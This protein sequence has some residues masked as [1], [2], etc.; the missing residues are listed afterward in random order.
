MTISVLDIFLSFFLKSRPGLRQL[1][2]DVANE[3]DLR[4]KRHKSR[5]ELPK[6]SE[7]QLKDIGITREQAMNEANR[8]FWD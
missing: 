3:L 7:A 1:L 8:D 5:A 4:H 2:A 6:L